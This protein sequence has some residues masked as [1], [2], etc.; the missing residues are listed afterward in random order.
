[1]GPSPTR[2]LKKRQPAPLPRGTPRV[3]P[4]PSTSSRSDPFPPP[5]PPRT[6]R[7]VERHPGGR[8]GNPTLTRNSKS[9]PNPKRTRCGVIPPHPHSPR[10]PFVAHSIPD[11]RFP[12]GIFAS[13]PALF[14]KPSLA[15]FLPRSP[16]PECALALVFFRC[17]RRSPQYPGT[18]LL[19][20][21][22][23]H[24][25]PVPPSSP[26]PP[27]PGGSSVISF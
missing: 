20:S 10:D 25:L 14:S 24:S 22:P 18:K 23:S 2:G 6:P 19:S 4:S 21:R 16:A 8:G 1:M 17:H 3:S 7:G 11:H 5:P 12:P 27:S 9:H 13:P 26:P 15:W